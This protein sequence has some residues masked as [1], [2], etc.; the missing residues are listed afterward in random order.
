[1][2]KYGKTQKDPKKMNKLQKQNSGQA[3]KNP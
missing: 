2:R 1:M 3:Q